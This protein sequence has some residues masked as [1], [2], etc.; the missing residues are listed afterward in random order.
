MQAMILAAGFGTR[1]L[2]YSLVR[3][4]PL[5]PILNRPLLLATIERLKNAGFTTITVNCH[6]LRQQIVDAII[7]IPGIIVQEELE[8][9]GT[10]G[11]LRCAL[12]H[13]D[14]E[15]LFV[16]N[17]DIYHT[18]DYAAVY[19]HHLNAGSDI[20]MVL[21]DCQRFNTVSVD[22]DRVTGFESRRNLPDRKAFTGLQVINP[23]ILSTIEPDTISCIIEHYRTI[24]DTGKKIGTFMAEGANWTDMGT[25]HDYLDLHKELLLGDIPVWPELHSR[26]KSSIF[27][28]VDARCDV[29][30]KFEQWACVGKAHIDVGATVKRSV[31]WDGAM[32]GAQTNLTDCIV[33]PDPHFDWQASFAD[34]HPN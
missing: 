19:E 25:A 6:H 5:F 29:T 28:D 14:D 30:T 33:T 8:I 3:P 34:G 22:E 13:L 2:P 7:E 17:G 21:H 27:I 16:T 24:L 31:V 12:N 20:T 11:G 9:L 32:V 23:E 26:H 10:G 15:P 1:L 18:I 4:K